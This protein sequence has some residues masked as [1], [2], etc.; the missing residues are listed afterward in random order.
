MKT[1]YLMIHGQVQGVN[2]RHSM[3]R[4]AQRLSVSGWVRNC[5]DG[6]VEAMVQGTAEALDALLR[7]AR[8]GPERAQVERIDVRAAEGSYSGFAVLG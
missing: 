1:L 6:T 3:R 7:W 4:E 2:Y 5:N 8:R